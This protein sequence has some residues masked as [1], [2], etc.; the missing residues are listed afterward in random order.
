MPHLE[1]ATATVEV[2]DG[3]KTGCILYTPPLAQSGTDGFE[4]SV[5]ATGRGCGTAW[6]TIYI[7]C[8]YFGQPFSEVDYLLWKRGNLDAISSIASTWE[9]LSLVKDL[10]RRYRPTSH[11][12]DSQL[13]SLVRQ[14]KEFSKQALPDIL[15]LQYLITEQLTTAT[16][17]APLLCADC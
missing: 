6:V 3:Q 10:N 11:L 5:C 1:G 9:K 4:Y 17:I 7:A 2:V 12:L 13:L 15:L 14:L 8:E 16:D